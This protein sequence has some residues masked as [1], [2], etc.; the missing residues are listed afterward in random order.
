MEFELNK[1]TYKQ[2]DDSLTQT[3]EV[4]NTMTF[5]G[6]DLSDILDNISIFLR[7]CGFNHCGI[8]LSD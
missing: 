2:L 6:E 1:C 5:Q 8:K 7:G 3:G 4:S